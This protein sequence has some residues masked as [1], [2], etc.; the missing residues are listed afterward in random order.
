VLL[1][2]CLDGSSGHSLRDQQIGVEWQVWPV[3]LD[4]TERLHNDARC[5]ERFIELW[6][7]EFVEPA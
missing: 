1:P 2:D 5:A 4:G 7:A 3:L 6:S